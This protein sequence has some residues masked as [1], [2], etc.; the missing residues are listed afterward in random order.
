MAEL[1]AGGTRGARGAAA[2]RPR[3]RPDRRRRPARST[4]PSSS[5]RCRGPAR[6]W[7]SAAT[8]ASTSTRRASTPPPAPLVFAKWPSSRHR[9]RRRDPLGSGADGAGR[10]RGRARPSSS[11]GRPAGS[12]EAE[13]L[14]HV[15]GYT[16][17]NDVSA[18]DIQFGDGQWVRGK[19]LDTFCPMG[20]V[21]RHRRRDR[22]TRRTSRSRAGSTASVVQD[23]QHRADVLRRRGDHQLLLAVVHARARRRDRDRH[24][25]RRRRSS[26]T[27]RVLLGDGDEVVVEIERIG[28]L[29]ERLPA[30]AGRGGRRA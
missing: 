10:L 2:A 30:R 27:R 26:A 17:L 28:R 12:S 18:R 8:T 5:R 9:A 1:L 13:A 11:A 21:A 7:R 15:L 6:S 16:C 4:R 25:G 3:R 23:A 20:P 29:V 14:D 24:A 19:S 22:A